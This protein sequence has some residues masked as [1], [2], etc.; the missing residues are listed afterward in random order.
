MGFLCS[1]KQK[2]HNRKKDL[3]SIMLP[4]SLWGR[5]CMPAFLCMNFMLSLT[6]ELTTG[7][8]HSYH[9]QCSCN[10]DIYLEKQLIFFFKRFYSFYRFFFFF[11]T[12]YVETNTTSI[13][14]MNI[15]CLRFQQVSWGTVPKT[16]CSR[17][18][19]M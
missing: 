12:K 14:S 1:A 19:W 6:T 8:Q 10:K 18:K 2:Q 7:R 11:P 3:N 17:L 15:N 9:S 13:W 5:V 16:L 4:W